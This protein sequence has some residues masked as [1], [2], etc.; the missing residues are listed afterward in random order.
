MYTSTKISSYISQTTDLVS[1]A[2]FLDVHECTLVPRDQV[3]SVKQLI[4]LALQ[5]FLGVRECTLVP[6]DQV[7]SVK[8]LILL[9]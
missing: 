5:F 7:T 6:R 2:V 9:V 4:L 1:T 8:Q 3:T